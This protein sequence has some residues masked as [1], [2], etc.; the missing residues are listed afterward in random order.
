MQRYTIIIIPF[1]IRWVSMYSFLIHL[2]FRMH[3]MGACFN[4]LLILTR[5]HFIKST[6]PQLNQWPMFYNIPPSNVVACSNMNCSNNMP[7][8]IVLPIVCWNVKFV[9]LFNYAVACHFFTPQI[10]RMAQRLTLNAL[11]R[12]MF[13]WIGIKVSGGSKNRLVK[14][15]KKIWLNFSFSVSNDKHILAKN[16]WCR[17]RPTQYR[18]FDSMSG[19]FTN[20]L[21]TELSYYS[22]LLQNFNTNIKK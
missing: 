10:F 14:K 15:W 3:K 22:N 17:W 4:Y 11:W 20:L 8:I 13:A 21:K 7:V 1:D 5:R 6:Q 19:L 18:R 2:I 12:I 16:R 9:T